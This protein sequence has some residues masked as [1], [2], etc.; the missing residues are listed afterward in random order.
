[1]SQAGLLIRCFQFGLAQCNSTRNPAHL[2][3]E[4]SAVRNPTS[5]RPGRGPFPS[6]TSPASEA[7]G[8]PSDPSAHRDQF[9]YCSATCRTPSEHAEY[10]YTTI[11]RESR[12]AV[13]RDVPGDSISTTRRGPLGDLLAHQHAPHHMVSSLPACSPV[14]LPAAPTTAIGRIVAPLPRYA[15]SC[16]HFE[17]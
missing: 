13:I 2:Q 7:H 17:A 11:A 6:S 1:M 10:S 9:P 16:N 14:P 3:Y 8:P 4:P 12:V 5:P 15:T